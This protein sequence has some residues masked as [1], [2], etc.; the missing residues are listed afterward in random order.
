MSEN[1]SIEGQFRPRQKPKMKNDAYYE[2]YS[3]ATGTRQSPALAMNYP[4]PVL[5]GARIAASDALGHAVAGDAVAV[6]NIEGKLVWS[7]PANAAPTITLDELTA[8]LLAPAKHPKTT[9]TL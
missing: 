2:I 1:A 7:Q 6:R 4:D 8:L 3:H 9:I 5:S